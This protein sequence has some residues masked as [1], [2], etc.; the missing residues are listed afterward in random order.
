LKNDTF[1]TENLRVN[2]YK[3]QLWEYYGSQYVPKENVT[4]KLVR[5][6]QCFYR[7]KQKIRK[8][9]NSITLTEKE[10]IIETLETFD[11]SE[12]EVNKPEDVTRILNATETNL[13]ETTVKVTLKK[14]KNSVSEEVE[15]STKK[16]KAKDE[17]LSEKMENKKTKK[18][19]ESS[20]NLQV[21][22]VIESNIKSH[23]SG[24]SKEKEKE[25]DTN[26]KKKE[27]LSLKSKL[28][29]IK[30]KK[31]LASGAKSV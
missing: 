11:S 18:K 16:S 22:E 30:S 23:T 17:S 8:G 4:F 10:E 26:E 27:K 15:I 24:K 25:R 3:K 9:P 19:K 12:L 21:S 20:E 31:A 5:F 29:K 7:M 13:P 14:K 2:F 6:S 1:S 28:K